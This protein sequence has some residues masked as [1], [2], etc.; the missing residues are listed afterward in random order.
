MP[1]SSPKSAGLDLQNEEHHSIDLD[2]GEN[3]G[4]ASPFPAPIDPVISGY[5][6]Q[7]L[8][9]IPDIDPEYAL[10]LVIQHYSESQA[11]VVEPVLDV[12]LG[13]PNYRKAKTKG[14]RKR[15]DDGIQRD[16]R[17]RPKAKSDYAGTD[18]KDEGGAHDAELSVTAKGKQRALQ[19]SQS[20]KEASPIHEDARV[21]ADE[22]WTDFGIECGCCFS[23]YPFVSAC[24]VSFPTSNSMPRTK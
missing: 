17:G 3:A 19:N 12:L 8:E 6:A 21:D 14:K 4:E 22:L 9:I 18:G 10:Y 15:I 16:A 24:T 7:V 13:D 23:T 1:S 20:E 2:G 5:V 11:Q